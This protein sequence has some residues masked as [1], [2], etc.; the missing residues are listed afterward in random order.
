MIDLN[1]FELT[2]LRMA[3]WRTRKKLV[4]KILIIAGMAGGVK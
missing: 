1:E 3:K 2:K 4:G